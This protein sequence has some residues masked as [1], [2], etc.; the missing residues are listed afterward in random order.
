MK[1]LSRIDPYPNDP[2]PT[3]TAEE[4]RFISRLADQTPEYLAAV[5]Q[6][7]DAKDQYHRDIADWR[8]RRKKILGRNLTGPEMYGIF[9]KSVSFPVPIHAQP[10]QL[11]GGGDALNRHYSSWAF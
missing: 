5:Q 2:Y 11:G 9:D 10:G 7:E 6:Y 3:F 4:P 8:T 1:P